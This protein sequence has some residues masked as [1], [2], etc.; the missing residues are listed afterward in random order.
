M[1]ATFRE[2]RQQVTRNVFLK[3]ENFAE[4]V[5]Y[6]PKGRPARTVHVHVAEE[7]EVQTDEQGNEH[8]IE[9][10]VCLCY[11]DASDPDVGGIEEPKFG[12]AIIRLAEHD[13]NPNR[14]VFS[15]EK[16]D[17]KPHKWRLVFIR[18]RRTAQAP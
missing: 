8:H 3:L 5:T 2:L 16:R 18:N 7:T 14:Y 13:P 1:V 4:Q 15:G 9:K 17:V 11:R 12:D 6:A 10:I